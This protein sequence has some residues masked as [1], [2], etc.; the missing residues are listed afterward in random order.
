MENRRDS[1]KTSERATEQAARETSQQATR[2]VKEPQKIRLN[3]SAQA[4]R[5][6][7]RDAPRETRLMAA[8]GA[9]PL[10]ATELATVLFALMHDP[11]AEIKSTARDSLENLPELVTDS[12]L[13]GD[14]HPAVLS[15][16]AHRFEGNEDAL[17]KIA[18]NPATSDATIARLA[19][20][21]HKKV[22]DIVSGNQERMLREPD[23]V[24][25]L[26]SNP[27]TGRAELERIL[28][29]L[30]A[31]TDLDDHPD[32]SAPIS[33][34]DAEAALRAV[35]GESMGKF[36]GQFVTESDNGEDAKSASHGI[37]QLIQ[38]MSVFQKV[39][40]ARLGNKEAR[41]LLVRDRN[42]LVA[43]SVVMSPKISDSEVLTIAQSRN[44]N[45]EVLRVISRG[46]DWTKNYQVKLALSTNPKCPLPIAMKF[47]NYLR[48]KDLRV[49]VRSR[50]VP[51]GISTHA[52]RILMKKG[53]L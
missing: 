8:R 41:S 33:D 20:S 49:L 18:L 28:S 45:D 44:V 31:P 27:L 1:A 30:D 7:R 32:P 43:L 25:A 34:D 53:K 39:K 2:Q 42:K 21:P 29:F 3:L 10:P 9:L 40:L 23:I 6:A 37:Y 46:R 14:T 16:F 26:G 52:R 38:K 36:A 13:V 4:K 35:L 24:E 51:R 50:D 47:V 48:D 17:E 12:V 22:I 11:D 15:L 19:A 5:Y